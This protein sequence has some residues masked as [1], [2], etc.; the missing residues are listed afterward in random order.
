MN[1]IL[2]TIKE[3]ILRLPEVQSRLGIS[4]SGIYQR[5]KEGTL[6]APINLGGRCMG[7]LES[8]IDSWLEER[9]ASSRSKD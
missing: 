2:P 6:P 1:E 3:R 5:I 7:F 4:R 8:E 9:I